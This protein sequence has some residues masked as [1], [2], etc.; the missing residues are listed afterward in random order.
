MLTVGVLTVG[1]EEEFLLLE[2]D[3]SVA[4]VSAGVLRVTDG[5]D[6]LRHEFTAYQLETA[7]GVHTRLDRLHDELAELRWVASRAAALSGA[8]LV[9]T[10]VPPFRRGPLEA[11]A[12]DARYH[13]LAARFPAATAAAAGTCGCHVHVGVADRDLAVGVLGR[14][15]PWLAPLLALSANS[16]FVG[17]ADTGLGSARY[18]ARRHWPTFRAPEAWADAAEYDRAIAGLI[19]DGTAL[20]VGGVHLLARLSGRFPTIELR[21]ADTCLRAADTVLFAGIARALVATL[22]DDIRHGRPAERRGAGEVEEDLAAAARHGLVVRGPQ[23]PGRP[24]AA[25]ADQLRVLLR[26]ITPALAEFGDAAAVHARLG[27]LCHNGTGAERQR[28]L[29]HHDPRPRAFIAALADH[30]APHSATARQLAWAV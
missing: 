15:R 2:P 18:E 3:G 13:R 28:T 4:P 16:P 19:A 24:A 25:I 14:L 1:V 23:P 26:K 20:D 10:G 11:L 22:I 27:W 12:D 7:S 6:R 17:G 29:R 21:V 8:R 9:A 30:T 5:D